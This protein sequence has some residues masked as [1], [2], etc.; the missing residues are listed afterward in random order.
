MISPHLPRRIA[1]I[2][3][4]VFIVVVGV[5]NE[6]LPTH[7]GPEMVYNPTWLL[8][9]LQTVFIFATSSL[10]A[11]ISL[12]SYL[13]GGTRAIL[14]LGC[15]SLTWGLANMIAAFLYGPP[16]GTNVVVTLVSSAGL[17]ASFFYVTSAASTIA[18][19]AR[20]KSWL[21]ARLAISYSSVIAFFAALTVLAIAGLT[22]AFFVAGSGTTMVRQFVVITGVSLFTVA[23]II[24]ARRFYVS[25]SGIL[26]WYSMALALTATGIGASFF[27]RAV[28]DPI[29]WASRIA[30]YLGGIYFLITVWNA[31][32]PSRIQP[33]S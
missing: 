11:Y 28:G 23:S 29:A 21:K 32:H 33:A 12:R 19:T 6:I 16:G 13:L 3:I 4:P 31:F 27:G 24:F 9:V 15:G 17:L 20:D 8:L 18:G 5:L 30:I 7:L 14:L 2:P 10:V 25:K 22:P 26:F 1:A